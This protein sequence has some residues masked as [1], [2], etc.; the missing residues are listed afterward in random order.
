MARP[1]GRFFTERPLTIT[2]RAFCERTAA[3]LLAGT[4][5]TTNAPLFDALPADAL[6]GVL[7]G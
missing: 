7:E 6:R 1:D 5:L 2:R 3:L 4:A